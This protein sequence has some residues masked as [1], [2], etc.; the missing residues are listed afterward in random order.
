MAPT[1][2]LIS[3]ACYLCMAVVG[4][5]NELKNIKMLFVPTEVM[6]ALHKNLTAKDLPPGLPGQGTQRW[7]PVQL[8]G[9]RTHTFEIRINPGTARKLNI[10]FQRFRI[11]RGHGLLLELKNVSLSTK[12]KT[13]LDR[14]VEFYKNCGG[15]RDHRPGTHIVHHSLPMIHRHNPHSLILPGDIPL[16]KRIQNALER[17]FPKRH[18][19]SVD[20]FQHKDSSGAVHFLPFEEIRREV[21][22]LIKRTLVK[23]DCVKISTNAL[24]RALSQFRRKYDNDTTT[25][26]RLDE[27][28][29]EGNKTDSED[30]R[31]HNDG[32][33]E[34]TDKV[35]Q[36]GGKGE[37]TDGINHNDGEGEETDEVLSFSRDLD[38]L[39]PHPVNKV[40][41]TSSSAINVPSDAAATKIVSALTDLRKELKDL[42]SGLISKVSQSFP[43]NFKE[44]DNK[45]TSNIGISTDRKTGGSYG[46]MG[47]KIK[48][49]TN[50]TT[51]EKNKSNHAKFETSKV[52]NRRKKMNSE[53]GGKQNKTIN[54]VEN[55]NEDNDYATNDLNIN[56]KSIDN[57]R[58]KDEKEIAVVL[59]LKNDLQKAMLNS[60]KTISK[61]DGDP[62]SV[63]KG[64]NERPVNQ[65]ANFLQRLKT[66]EEYRVTAN[67]SAHAKISDEKK[68]VKKQTR[69][70]STKNNAKNKGKH[71][72][73]HRDKKT[74]KQ[75]SFSF[76]YKPK[77]SRLKLH[78]KGGDYLTAQEGSDHKNKGKGRLVH[79]IHMRRPKI[80]EVM[81]PDE[82]ESDAYRQRNFNDSPVEAVN[83]EDSIKG[84]LLRKLRWL[85]IHGHAPEVRSRK[86]PKLRVVVYN[87]EDEDREPHRERWHDS[88]TDEYA[89]KL[90]E[91]ENETDLGPESVSESEHVSDTSHS[92]ASLFTDEDN[93]EQF[94]QGEAGVSKSDSESNMQYLS[95][96]IGDDTTH[97]GQSDSGSDVPDL[98]P[99][100]KKH[101]DDE[102]DE[103]NEEIKMYNEQD[104]IDTRKLGD[105]ME[106]RISKTP[107]D[108]DK[109]FDEKTNNFEE[110]ND[111]DSGK[112]HIHK[113][114]F[115]IQE[116][117][118]GVDTN[119][120]QEPQHDALGLQRV[121]GPG[122]DF[123]SM[124][125]QPIPFASNPS[126]TTLNQNAMD[127]SP[128][129]VVPPQ[130]SMM[131]PAAGELPGANG[132]TTPVERPSP[133]AFTGLSFQ[134][135]VTT[136][137]NS[138]MP[139]TPFPQVSS[140]MPLKSAASE[141]PQ[142]APIVPIMQP[143]QI[144]A[145]ISRSKTR[146]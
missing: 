131:I 44:S 93:N 143:G 22:N 125:S 51:D 66:A 72:G 134:P 77:S 37:K 128:N 101:Y 59:R 112:I 121:V 145:V 118:D 3:L 35:N 78:A 142:V 54:R 105:S 45:S 80:K 137:I 34:E 130:Q 138:M 60:P 53:D 49:D 5:D 79:F 58:S 67:V 40:D 41:L 98:E 56:S 94:S 23:R 47:N 102:E 119:L 97:I 65:T 126:T 124:A 14:L 74:K 29:D 27:E 73:R 12:G 57:G 120:L 104:E 144:R 88:N 89:G 122:P 52:K 83:D 50:E 129:M 28:N 114:P 90:H 136:Q 100:L 96:S 86:S 71:K 17:F 141:E 46:N 106:K 9:D 10:N 4:Q 116:D 99:Y 24:T 113:I 18:D 20:V 31:A 132:A 135:R 13:V 76:H 43:N 61:I 7:T 103:E 115:K 25:R 16:L 30:K 75:A 63:I 32:K 62:S 68:K 2:L 6:K 87:D 70:K 39:N 8:P 139:Q 36:E 109:I 117:S 26:P 42:S 107:K 82:D 38:S 48:S 1:I 19:G 55:K 110:N 95:D 33:G 64:N 69:T 21:N 133:A 140:M 92:S 127:M 85:R 91:D 123:S 15:D 81:F 11:G 108:D 146:N 84:R 111:E